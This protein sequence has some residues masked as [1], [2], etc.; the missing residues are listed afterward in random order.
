MKAALPA[1]REA[2]LLVANTNISGKF[3]KGD[4]MAM[5]NPN[6]ERMSSKPC[7]IDLLWSGC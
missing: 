1:L 7:V 3:G 2:W 6:N 4:A 5:Q